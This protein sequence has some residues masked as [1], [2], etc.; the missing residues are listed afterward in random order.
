MAKLYGEDLDNELADWETKLG[1]EETSSNGNPYTKFGHH[2][3]TMIRAFM[4]LITTFK[5]KFGYEQKDFVA[6]GEKVID[7]LTPK[8][9][10]RT[11]NAHNNWKKAR[12]QKW[13]SAVKTVFKDAPSNYSKDDI[14]KFS[15]PVV[16]T[17]E[18]PKEQKSVFIQR[19]TL[20]PGL[21]QKL[22]DDWVGTEEIDILKKLGVK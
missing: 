14:N 10:N 4:V 7:R 21:G 22:P 16:S 12:K 2:D 17:P 13:E 11:V 5:D 8:L 3:R 20:E 9:A 18:L 1:E 6:V 15:D 19:P